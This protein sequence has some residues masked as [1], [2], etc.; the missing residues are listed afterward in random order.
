MHTKEGLYEE[1]DS[2]HVD[3]PGLGSIRDLA[4]M[5][6][7]VPSHSFL[8]R[9]HGTRRD[10]MTLATR[11]DELTDNS[12]QSGIQENQGR[13]IRERARERETERGE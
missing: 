9:M 4:H 11:I 6:M 1:R 5:A 10:A 13:L 12:R 3:L 8:S 7:V 2:L